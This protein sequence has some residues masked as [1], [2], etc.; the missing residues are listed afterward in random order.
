MTFVERCLYEYKA[1]VAAIEAINLEMQ[2]LMSV[3]GHNYEGFSPNLNNVSD[4][5]VEVTARKVQLENKISWLKRLTAPVERLQA[6]LC[7]SELRIQQ[8]RDILRLKYIGN[9]RNDDVIAEMYISVPTYWR[10]VR[11]L[12]RM[13]RKY[14]GDRS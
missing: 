5:V 2:D 13:A 8:M 1:N 6:D 12:L 7:G 11:E 10:R 9:N 14:F 4:P 3:R